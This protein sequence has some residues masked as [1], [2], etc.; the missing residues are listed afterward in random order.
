MERPKS[1][2]FF[3]TNKDSTNKFFKDSKVGSCSHVIVKNGVSIAVPFR[4]QT[5]SYKTTDTFSSET[6]ST[7]R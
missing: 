1:S 2:T 3:K 6:K 4:V 7:Y 5:A